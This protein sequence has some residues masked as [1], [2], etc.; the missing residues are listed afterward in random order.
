[1][2][3]KPV[4]DDVQSVGAANGPQRKNVT[5]PVGSAGFAPPVTLIVAMSCTSNVGITGVEKSADERVVRPGTQFANCPMTKSLSVAV[6]DVDD[7]VSATMLEKH[8]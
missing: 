6:V 4:A 1:M 2:F 7:R 8:S 3:V 5:V